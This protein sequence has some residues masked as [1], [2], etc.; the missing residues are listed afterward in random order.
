MLT[1]VI[2]EHAIDRTAPTCLPGGAWLWALGLWVDPFGG[3]VGDGWVSSYLDLS[4]KVP[5]N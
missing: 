4:D 2:R 5:D 1:R 3:K